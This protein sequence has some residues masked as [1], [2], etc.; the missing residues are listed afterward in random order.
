VY[1]GSNVLF[2]VGRGGS[3]LRFAGAVLLVAKKYAFMKISTKSK[4]VIFLPEE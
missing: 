3:K 4:N 2:G 1:L